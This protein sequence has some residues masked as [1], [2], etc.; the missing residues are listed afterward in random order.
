VPILGRW[1]ATHKFRVAVDGGVINFRALEQNLEFL[2]D[3][4]IDFKL[5]KNRL[6][7]EKNVPLIPFDT[8]TLVYWELDSDD[9]QRARDRRVSLRTLLRPQVPPKRIEEARADAKKH[10]RRTGLRRLD[11]EN[12]D[13]R[14]R[15]DSGATL[16]ALG[17]VVRFGV[18]PGN[19]ADTDAAVAEPDAAGAAII[20]VR[21]QL[22]HHAQTDGPPGELVLEGAELN[23]G[24]HD[25]AIGDRIVSAQSIAI[26]AIDP[27]QLV[28][29]GL[30][31]GLARVS[32]RG[33]CLTGLDYAPAD[34][35]DA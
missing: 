26:E 9:L 32:V 20:T 11:V 27:A 10:G 8:K 25:V 33:V 5:R 35:R 3:L 18:P 13:V 19:G 7:L 23:A 12:I 2:E 34:A 17:G 6:V 4:I 16:A 28:T 15:I 22:G 29:D 31:P 1:R 21:G 14:L 30:R 24:V